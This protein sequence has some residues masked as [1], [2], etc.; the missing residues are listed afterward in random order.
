MKLFDRFRDFFRPVPGDDR[1][2][3][4]KALDDRKCPD[5]GSIHLIG[6]PRG[7]ASQNIA[8]ATCK[9]EFNVLNMMGQLMLIDR[10]GKLTSQRA[11]LYGIEMADAGDAI[12]G[13]WDPAR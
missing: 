2:A 9:S 8:C 1:D 6:G 5:C 11:K 4:Q 7:G 13:E 3:D 12:V 10:M